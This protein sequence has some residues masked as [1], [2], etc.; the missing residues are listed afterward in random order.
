[1]LLKTF[2]EIICLSHWT[3]CDMIFCSSKSKD[4]YSKNLRSRV[5]YSAIFMVDLIIWMFL[6]TSMATYLPL[7]YGRYA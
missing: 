7:F 4:R 2:F 3:F 5:I 1:M 6:R